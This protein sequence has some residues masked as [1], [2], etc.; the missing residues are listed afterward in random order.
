MYKLAAIEHR[1][2]NSRQVRTT[3][4]LCLHTLEGEEVWVD[5]DE[6]RSIRVNPKTGTTRVRLGSESPDSEVEVRETV[7]QVREARRGGFLRK[8]DDDALQEAVFAQVLEAHPHLAMKERAEGVVALAD[9]KGGYP[10]EMVEYAFAC[11]WDLAP[12]IMQNPLAAGTLLGQVLRSR[13]PGAPNILRL[14]PEL[15]VELMRAPAY[16]Y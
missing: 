14:S 15:A 1:K 3:L 10:L 16:R 13:D 5:S 7:D 6:L 12:R 8:V 4:D 2:S 11:L 9:D